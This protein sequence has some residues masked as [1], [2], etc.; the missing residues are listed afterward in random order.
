MKRSVMFLVVASLL[1]GCLGP[2]DGTGSAV[3]EAATVS[4]VVSITA[5]MSATVLTVTS[6]YM[7]LGWFTRNGG[8]DATKSP[9]TLALHAD[10]TACQPAL[11][12][13]LPASA[14][15]FVPLLNPAGRPRAYAW[16][17]TVDLAAYQNRWH[18]HIHCDGSSVVEGC[19]EA[20]AFTVTFSVGGACNEDTGSC[21]VSS[22]VSLPSAQD[23]DVV[24]TDCAPPPAPECPIG[25]CVSACQRA[26][27]LHNTSCR[28]CCECRCK[29]EGRAAG[30]L[31]CQPQELCYTGSE[32]HA[33]CL[34]R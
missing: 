18:N 4:N 27:G 22:G 1:G 8:F 2:E 11:D 7:P 9:I 25:P 3:G 29:A 33:V 21:T 13:S 23:P 32:G 15:T 30:N 12:L 16:T 31:A 28:T 26:C 19:A 20:R 10:A 14:G 6:G 5:S 17:A 34:S 24:D